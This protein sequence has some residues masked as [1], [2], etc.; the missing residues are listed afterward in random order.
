MGV[1]L[2]PQA[3]SHIRDLVESG[4]YPNA[5]AVID[6]A[7]E[8]LDAQEQARFLKLRELVL[9]GFASPSA[10]ELTDEMWDEIE[11]SSEERFQRG[12]EPS[13]HVCP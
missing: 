11:Q 12:E 8:A 5:A 1:T 10:G 2:T 4:H 9:A 6:K 13:S 3:E 7:L